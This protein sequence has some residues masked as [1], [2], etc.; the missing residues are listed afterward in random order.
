LEQTGIQDEAP[1][2][3]APIAATHSWDTQVTKEITANMS[4]TDALS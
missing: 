3:F 2:D 1:A 4:D